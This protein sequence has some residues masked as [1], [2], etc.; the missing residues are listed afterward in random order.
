MGSKLCSV[1]EKTKPLSMFGNNKRRKSGIMSA[2]KACVKDRSHRLFNQDP[3]RGR[4][5]TQWWA[6]KMRARKY[7][8]P[9]TITQEFVL[10]LDYNRCQ[11][12][13]R[14]LQIARSMKYGKQA[15]RPD[16][17]SL[18]RF[19]P[20]LGYVPGN[21]LVLCHQCNYTKNGMS[22]LEMLEMGQKLLALTPN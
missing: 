3:E 7:K 19:I 13:S 10:A 22:A 9:F 1:C 17:P 18:D 6:A 14:D 12:C 11:L 21:I 15:P 8:V 20:K 4:R 5:I 16:A 2:C